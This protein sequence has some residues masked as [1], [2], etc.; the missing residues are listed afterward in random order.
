MRFRDVGVN[1]DVRIDELGTPEQIIAGFAPEIFGGPISD[2]DDI[3]KT[4]IITKDGDV[5]YYFWEVKPHSLVAATAVG[6]RLFMQ[7][8]TANNRQ[9]RKSSD[10]LR[11]IQKSFHV[12]KQ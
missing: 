6:N 1:A 8:I 10:E 5:P 12:P 4:E 11:V 9:W 2:E 3:F 7:V